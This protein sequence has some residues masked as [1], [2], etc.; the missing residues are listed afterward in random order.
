[1]KA[2]KTFSLISEVLQNPSSAG[3]GRDV[4]LALFLS[5]NYKVL[6]H[7]VQYFKQN[8][9][10]K[11]WPLTPGQ[12]T[13]Y[14]API[15]T[16]FKMNGKE[17]IFKSPELSIGTIWV[18][19]I[20]SAW[21]FHDVTR[22]VA[23]FRF[24]SPLIVRANFVNGNQ[25]QDTVSWNISTFHIRTNRKLSI[26]KVMKSKRWQMNS[27][28]VLYMTTDTISS[29]NESV[30]RLVAYTHLKQF[31][32]MIHNCFLVL[33]KTIHKSYQWKVIFCINK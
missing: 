27:H 2:C 1:M 17:T 29:N 22:C 6:H 11:H 20:N 3:R 15:L 19:S 33:S 12:P 31:T 25:A 8:F 10:I 21:N 18:H 16:P 9:K 32:T 23:D 26:R 7:S 5:K 4:L 30:N 13:P 24:S 14:W 28:T